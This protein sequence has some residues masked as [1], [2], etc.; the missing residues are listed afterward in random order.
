VLG[1]I[2]AYPKSLPC[3]LSKK[4]LGMA[5]LKRPLVQCQAYRQLYG[6]NA[7]YLLPVNLY[8]PS[9]NFD[10]PRVHTNPLPDP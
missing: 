10:T 6:M 4:A 8:G 3:H 7:I 2:W 5:T 1:T 9:N